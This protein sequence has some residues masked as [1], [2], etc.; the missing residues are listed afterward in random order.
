[1]FLNTDRFLKYAR[2]ALFITLVGSTVSSEVS[3]QSVPSPWTAKDIGNP[4]IASTTTY[5]AGTY[6]VDEA[7]VDIWNTS[8]QFHFIYQQIVGD[9]D[10]R[11][12]VRSVSQANSWSKTGVMIRETLSPGSRHAFALLSAAK[13]YGYHRR[14]DPNGFSESGT[15]VT[16]VAPGWVRLVRAGSRI[17]AFR[18]TDGVTWISLGVD[19][20]P[21]VETVYVGIATTSHNATAKTKAMLDSLTVTGTPVVPPP[22]GNT[23]PTVA[24]TAPA[25]GATYTAPASVALTATASDADGSVAKVEFYSGATLLGTDTSSPYSY[26]WSSVPAGSYSLTAAAYDNNGMKVTS[27]ARTITVTGTGSAIPAP[28]VAGDVGSPALSGSTSYA[29]GVFTVAGAGV[30]IWGTADQF[31][32][33]YQP[34]AGDVEIVARV[35]SLSTVKSFTSAGVMIRS[36]LTTNAAQGFSAVIAGGGTYFRRRLTTGA[37]TTSTLGASTAA[38]VWVRL[39]RKGTLVTS[40]SSTDGATWTTIGSATLG[41]SSTAY[42]GLAVNSLDATA[43]ATAKFSNVR[44]T[45]STSNQ[46]P[47]VSLTSPASGATYT[48]PASVDLTATASDT[49][50]SVAKVEFYSGATLL[51]TDTS[52]PYSFTW[53]S[54]PA[55]T[56]SLTAVAYDNLGAKT[57]SAARSITVT[58]TATTPPTSIVFQKSV[59]HTS[60]TSYRLDVFASGANPATATPLATSDLGKPTPATN[61]DITV[62]RATFFSALAAGNYVATVSAIGAS[63][64]S[65]SASVTFSR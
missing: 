50:G 57:T 39:V 65:R 36:G 33:V 7:G 31:Q 38:P 22:A 29:S 59:D 40:Y 4:A 5:S 14:I 61:G 23:A 58:G 55:G 21:M 25:S 1:M 45:T 47:V 8:D 26:T 35:D 56:Y 6:T 52:S 48:A 3:A 18:S 43:R 60:V 30:D 11:V 53:S 24:L 46:L 19:V 9:V 54:V 28:W 37:T 15:G 34:V 12:R 16:G 20:V 63:G 62:N 13:G 10:I 2:L 42:V 49:D 17:E 64:S 44:V 51:G 32:F 27:A 41:L